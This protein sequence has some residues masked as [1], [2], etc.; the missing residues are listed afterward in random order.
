VIKTNDIYYLAGWLEGEGCFS[1]YRKNH[2]VVSIQGTSTD[3]DT[4]EKVA[5]LLKA[6][7]YFYK[8]K[9]KN[10]S[11]SW[12][13]TLTGRKAIAWMMT[14]YPLMG[15]RRQEK[16]KECIQ[17]WKTECPGS[18]GKRYKNG[19]NSANQKKD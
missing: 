16:I 12:S 10:W 13:F 19:D 14:L 1:I 17:A 15:S 18:Y 11:S 6:K 8:P 7:T 9:N 4:L 2:T 3:K 5:S